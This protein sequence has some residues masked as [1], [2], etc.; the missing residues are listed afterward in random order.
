MYVIIHFNPLLKGNQCRDDCNIE[1]TKN[2]YFLS[3]LSTVTS[4]LY[5]EQQGLETH[6][7]TW[8]YSVGNIVTTKN[9]Y[10]LSLLSAVTSPLYSEQQGLETHA[11]TWRYSV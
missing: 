3:L 4:P 11:T 10:F 8:S 2:H 9:H 7:T 5:S 1:T 6:A